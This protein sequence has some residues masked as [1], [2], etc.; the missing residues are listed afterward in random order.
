MS[1]DGTLNPD[2]P[3]GIEPTGVPGPDADHNS[4]VLA[5]AALVAVL[6]LCF[7]VGWIAYH[8]LTSENAPPPQPGGGPTAL[9]ML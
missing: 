6:A 2:L 5:L 1:D 3:E 4:F 7:T 8:Q 9:V